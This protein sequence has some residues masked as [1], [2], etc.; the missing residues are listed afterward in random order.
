VAVLFLVCWIVARGGPSGAIESIAG[1]SQV[2]SGEGGDRDSWQQPEK[3][4]N[5]IGVKAG[6][7]IGEI[8]AGNG[9]FTFKMARR[10]GPTGLI[11][12]N[13]I[14]QDAL[15]SIEAGARRRKI[16]HIVTVRG[17]VADPLFPPGALDLVIMVYVF[18][19]LA[20]PVELLQNLKPSLKP[21]A[22]L[23]ILERDP[24]KMPNARGHFYDKDKLLELASEA[25]FELVRVETFL[26]RDNIYILRASDPTLPLADPSAA[27]QEDKALPAISHYNLSFNLLLKENRLEAEASIT[28]ENDSR[29]SVSEIPFILYRLFDVLEVT[30]DR[31]ITL[32]FNQAVVKFSDEKSLQVSLVSVR[33]RE[34][35][36]P[37]KTAAVRL[38]YA[39]ALWGYPEVMA[40]VRDRIDENYSLL[41]PDSLAYPMLARASFQSWM[42]AHR[43]QFTYRLETEVPAGYIV[44]CGGKPVET[45]SKTNTSTFVFESYKPT[46]RIDVAVAK[47]KVIEDESRKI[48]VFAI[49]GDEEDGRRILEAAQKSFRFYSDLLGEV[50]DFPGYSII[51]VPEGWGSQASDFY[52][53]QTAAAFQ[54]KARTSELYHEIAHSWNVRIKPGI[55]RCRY[56]D[57]AF[58]S[59]FQ[60]LAIREFEG[61]EAFHRFMS[62]LR[63]R[64]LQS[65]EK[66]EKN[67]STPISDYWREERGENSYTKGAWSLFVLHQVVGD[68]VFPSLVSGFLREFRT[69]EADFEDFQAFAE[70]AAGRNLDRFFKE[71]I[72]GT[73]SSQLLR[74]KLDAGK[75]GE[76]YR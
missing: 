72:F 18:H 30:D 28:V 69:R 55:Q 45:K 50:G 75:I 14:D 4:I 65:C 1:A 13:D 26:S 43:S 31:G 47:F 73:E 62:R 34:L 68:P 9:Y 15:R 52:I 6:M 10:V 3:V 25:G 7:T 16:E 64:F 53:L 41:R 22:S 66:D 57:E 29:N 54:D 8:G 36:S 44:A 39:G 56:F 11:Y 23:V 17:E 42:A 32:P 38:K 58:A 59:Y 21:S 33:L 2:P 27:N 20:K 60:G 71:W 46:W 67:C 63:D 49:S 76:R 48:R 37:G 35:L 61:E 19:D 51:E 5:A 24:D 70:K 40:Y 12:A 74:E